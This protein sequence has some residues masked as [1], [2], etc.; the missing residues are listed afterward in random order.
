[1]FSLT[2]EIR[3]LFSGKFNGF[4][5]ARTFVHFI[6]VFDL[7][8]TIFGSRDRNARSAGLKETLVSKALGCVKINCNSGFEAYHFTSEKFAV[9]QKM[10]SQARLGTRIYV[11]RSGAAI[12]SERYVP[13]SYCHFFFV[14]ERE[15]TK[16]DS[17]LFRLWI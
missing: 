9:V 3:D 10:D 8:P 12:K 4:V 11:P 14:R 2:S 13:A 16:I 7:S 1:M 6:F 5:L 17:P 15:E